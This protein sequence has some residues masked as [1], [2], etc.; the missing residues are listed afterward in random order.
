V[1]KLE[2]R[3]LLSVD[4][5]KSSARGRLPRNDVRKVLREAVADSLARNSISWADCFIHDLGDGLTVIAPPSTAK[6]DLLNTVIYDLALRLRQ[7]NYAEG[8]GSR[9]LIRVRVALHAGEV[10]LSDDGLFTG[11]PLEVLARLLDA[12]ELRGALQAAPADTPLA[13]IMSG[14]YYDDAV[15]YGSLSVLPEDFASRRVGVKEFE[16]EAWLF[17]PAFATRA[18]RAAQP[19]SNQPQPEPRGRPAD[20]IGG[21]VPTTLEIDALAAAG[22]TALVTA[23]A[24]DSWSGLK[25]LIQ[26]L[27]HRI[28]TDQAQAARGRL[29]SDAR[30]VGGARDPETARQELLGP[31]ISELSALL[32]SAPGSAE[33]LRALLRAYGRSGRPGQ[34]GMVVDQATIVGDGA[35]ATVV[36]VGDVFHVGI[37]APHPPLPS[38][39][40]AS[41]EAA[42]LSSEQA[43]T[44]STVPTEG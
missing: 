38:N 18:S 6:A 11:R 41:R 37:P 22:A 8:S 17:V 26:A 1:S 19:Q 15:K 24:T 36:G 31:W 25:K 7:H 28:G 30:L 16:G 39:A 4:V 23:M 14:H 40:R 9:K 33:E 5:E 34:I 42:G 21:T 32:R 13:L 2:Y 43:E 12:V 27:F 44:G 29:E 10:E 3:A 35:T 20:Y